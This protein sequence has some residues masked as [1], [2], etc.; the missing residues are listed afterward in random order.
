MSRAF[1][2][3]SFARSARAQAA[4]WIV[5]LAKGITRAG[6][7]GLAAQMSFWLFLALV[8][9]AAVAGL[10]AA[11]LATS[12]PWLGASALSSVPPQARDLLMAQ[13]DRVA[14]WRGGAVAP[15]AATTFLWLASS[16]VHAVFDALELQTGTSRPWWKKRLLAIATC[17]AL[18]VGVALL[19]L[20]GAGLER[21][22]ALL[23][24]DVP[25]ALLHA[26]QG[27][28][29]SAVRR[30]AGALI[31]VGMVAGLYRVGIA[32]HARARFPVLPGALLAIALQSLLGWGY[33]WYVTHAG[34][35]GSAY[36]A[37]LAAVGVTMMTLWLFSVALLAGAELNRVVAER[38]RPDSPWQRSAVSSSRP[39]S[40]RRPTGPSTGLSSSPPR[41]AR[42]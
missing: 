2:A 33:G 19:A 11:R 7:L 34:G 22:Q 28:L 36:Q 27:A 38:L 25:A 3:G 16:G 17:V 13:V 39:T 23:G 26:E 5:P 12:R 21:V 9:L 31:A 30:G 42:P 6:T 15:V 24:N 20:L 18:S 4:A 35:S 1:R 32:R 41:S 29:G 8:P 37:G 10:V 14:S 40:P